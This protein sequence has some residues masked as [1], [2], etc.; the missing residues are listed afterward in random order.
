MT[1]SGGSPGN[2]AVSTVA[3]TA[4]ALLPSV[5]RDRTM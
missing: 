1:A 4:A 5:D 2:A 3:D